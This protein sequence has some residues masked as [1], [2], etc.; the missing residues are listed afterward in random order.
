M[1]F[2]GCIHPIWSCD[3]SASAS[4][5]CERSP[6]EFISC[7]QYLHP[8]QQQ[9]KNENNKTSR[10]ETF[11]LQAKWD[12]K[13]TQALEKQHFSCTTS[14]RCVCV[15]DR[16]SIE[17]GKRADICFYNEQQYTHGFCFKLNGF[18]LPLLHRSMD[19]LSHN[20]QHIASHFVHM[21]RFHS[22][23]IFSHIIQICFSSSSLRLVYH[24]YASVVV[25]CLLRTH[26]PPNLAI[27]FGYY[28]E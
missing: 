10:P 26:F 13:G 4:D 7:I 1:E 27:V 22:P 21:L 5:K 14:S 18:G 25:C 28:T 11:R 2:F 19:Y 24:V 20:S 16:T 6:M 23:F 15:C 12:G 3:R 17:F 9:K 8:H